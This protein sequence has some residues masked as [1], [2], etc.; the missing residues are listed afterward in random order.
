MPRKPTEKVI[1]HRIT[2]GT[3]ER[4]IFSDAVTSYNFKNVSTPIVSALSDVSFVLLIGAAI[5]LFLDRVLPEDWRSVTEF[6]IG[7]DLSDWLEV[8][9]IVGAGIG[10]I[11]GLFF[12]NPVFGAVLGTV[13]VEGLE[14]VYSE[15]Q[16][17]AIENPKVTGA[18][19]AFM[20]RTYWAIEKIRGNQE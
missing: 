14:E 6:L 19:T 10:G 20:L 1:E 9:N 18:Y 15:V 2:L 7:Q 16:T 13:A 12:G 3:Y 8:Q 4:Q 5:G 17:T 11:A